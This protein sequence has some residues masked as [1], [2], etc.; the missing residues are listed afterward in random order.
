VPTAD[1]PDAIAS[2]FAA[3]IAEVVAQ[4]PAL[5]P[6]A[7][8]DAPA[9]GSTEMVEVFLALDPP[10]PSAGGAGGE[11]S[12]GISRLQG[13]GGVDRLEVMRREGA[14]VVRADRELRWQRRP[15]SM[16]TDG[17]VLAFDSCGAFPGGVYGPGSPGT[18]S[19]RISGSLET[20]ELA[21]REGTRTAEVSLRLTLRE[22]D[23]IARLEV[24][25]SAPVRGD[26]PHDVAQAM[27]AALGEAFAAS[28]ERVVAHGAEGG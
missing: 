16:V 25:G 2:A 22:G 5:V 14:H 18:P 7:P 6:T 8:L 20:F 3:A 17:L 19:L 28:V 12:I 9:P 15:A 13:V 10:M 21:D 1:D 4:A 11:G 27:S 24:S 23:R 26:A